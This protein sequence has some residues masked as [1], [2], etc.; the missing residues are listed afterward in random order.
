M[1]DVGHAVDEPDDLAL[2]GGRL[3]SP[4][5]VADDAVAD[6]HSQIQAAAVALERVHDSQRMFV[7]QEGGTE[8][9]AQAAIQRLFADVTEGRVAKIVAEPDRLHQILVEGKGPCH[10]PRDLG[11]LERMGEPSAVMVAARGHE[12]LRLVL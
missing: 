12:H 2:Q 10:G 1:V 5:G 4:A 9:I 6:G 7:V 11:H 8:V 3:G